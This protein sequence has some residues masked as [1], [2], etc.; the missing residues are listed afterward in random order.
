[1]PVFWRTSQSSCYQPYFLAISLY[2]PLAKGKLLKNTLKR[3]KSAAVAAEPQLQLSAALNE[4]R[5]TVHE[6]LDD[7]TN[8]PGAL[9][10]AAAERSRI[11]RF[12]FPPAE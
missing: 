5:R 7:G 8:S 2:F 6:F 3:L 4:L 10:S 1:M 11:N 12:I 9:Q